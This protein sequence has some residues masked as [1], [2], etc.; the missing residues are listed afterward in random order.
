MVTR[1]VLQW[2]DGDYIIAQWLD[3]DGYNG[4]GFSSTLRWRF[5]GHDV[6]IGSLSIILKI[7]LGW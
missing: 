3:F 1:E 7:R 5:D 2:F 6:A 4:S